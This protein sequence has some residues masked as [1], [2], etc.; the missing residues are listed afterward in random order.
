MKTFWG[1]I[2]YLSFLVGAVV[3]I[4]FLIEFV[5]GLPRQIRLAY[6]ELNGIAQHEHVDNPAYGDV[7]WVN[8]VWYQYSTQLESHWSPFVY[9][10]SAPLSSGVLNVDDLGRRKT[11]HNRKPSKGKPQ[12]QTY[13]FGGSTMWGWGVPDWHTVPSELANLDNDLNLKVTN[14]GQL[15][16]VSTQEYLQ[17]FLLLRNGAR[18]DVVVLYDGFNDLHASTLDYGPGVAFSE[19]DR[20]VE[21]AVTKR[22]NRIKA[23]QI[24]L[25]H[26]YSR[27]WKDARKIADSFGLVHKREISNTDIWKL[28]EEAI[29]IYEFNINA[30]RTLA[31]RYG[32]KPVFI[33]QPIK[34]VDP[35]NLPEPE[36]EASI[37]QAGY[38]IAHEKLSKYHDVYFADDVLQGNSQYYLDNVHLT[39]DGNKVVAEAISKILKGQLMKDG[40]R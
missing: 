8:D 6:L 13:L 10:K 34:G 31:D 1:A 25:K 24:A 22:E 5:P 28:A 11:V 18:P 15:G 7:P 23:Y 14:Y 16:Y 37:Y 29:R 3:L 4:T 9:W 30:I 33:L 38:R 21:Y 40:I 12:L 19:T 26:A 2:H 36:S 32:F 17:L 39:H 27:S 20:I 35:K